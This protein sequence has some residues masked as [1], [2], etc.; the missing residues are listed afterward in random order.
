MSKI[1]NK[2]V[3]FKE[4]RNHQSKGGQ[5]WRVNVEEEPYITLNNPSHSCP[6]EVPPNAKFNN[7]CL[8]EQCEG[9]QSPKYSKHLKKALPCTQGLP[10][11]SLKGESPMPRE[12][13]SKK[14]CPNRKGVRSNAITCPP[15]TDPSKKPENPARRY[16]DGISAAQLLTDKLKEMVIEEEFRK[17]TSTMRQQ[18]FK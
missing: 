10:D 13:V 6:Y 12:D 14:I 11:K 8:V 16:Y 4:K 18:L 9:T 3:T 15:N 7:P 5:E 17:E 2:K 1:S